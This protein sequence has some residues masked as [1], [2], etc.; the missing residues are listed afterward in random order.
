MYIFICGYSV[1]VTF[2]FFLYKKQW[3]NSQN[4]RNKHHSNQGN[5]DIF[6]IFWSDK[7]FKSNLVNRAFRLCMVTWNYADSSFKVIIPMFTEESLKI[8]IIKQDIRIYVPY[9]RPNGWTDWA[10]IFLWTLRGGRAGGD[11]G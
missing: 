5:D 10:E 6:H 9:S 8:Y 4:H 2:A 3:R 11:I 7:G 1:K